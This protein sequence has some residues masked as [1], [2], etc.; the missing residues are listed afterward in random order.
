MLIFHCR[1]LKLFRGSFEALG[2]PDDEKSV[3]YT[4]GFRAY[5]EAPWFALH[6]STFLRR[7]SWVGSKKEVPVIVP[8]KTD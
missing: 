2:I 8:K 4:T 6:Y 7:V 5:S 1:S 3:A